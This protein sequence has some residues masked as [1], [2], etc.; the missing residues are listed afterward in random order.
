MYSRTQWN[1]V[2][3]M[4]FDCLLSRQNGEQ[5]KRVTRA[6]G[7]R[8]SC[9]KSSVCSRWGVFVVFL[10]ERARLAFLGG[11]NLHRLLVAS[12]VFEIVLK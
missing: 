12:N 9:V 11:K 1:L 5:R 10:G 8:T 6:V 2:L 3:P 4:H 7:P